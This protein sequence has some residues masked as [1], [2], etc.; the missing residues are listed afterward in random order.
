MAIHDMYLVTG[1]RTTQTTYMA[2]D[3]CP[4]SAVLALTLRSGDEVPLSLASL[5]LVGDLAPLFRESG[6]PLQRPLKKAAV[7]I[8]AILEFIEGKSAEPA[9]YAEKEI[10]AIESWE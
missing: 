10:L 3:T 4:G 5:K 9:L 2:K 8:A 1:N 7:C 6:R